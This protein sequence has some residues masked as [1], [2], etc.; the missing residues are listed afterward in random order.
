LVNVSAT[1]N[2][3]GVASVGYDS[4]SQTVSGVGM[5]N[6]IA[7][8]TV[9]GQVETVNGY[10]PFQVTFMVAVNLCGPRHEG[11]AVIPMPGQ[12]VLPDPGGG[13][14]V[15]GIGIGIGIGG[16]GGDRDRG[17]RGSRDR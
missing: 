6:G 12:A 1:S 7:Q 9:T 15:P 4:A 8:I 11:P 13:L 16:H 17:S 2:N 3:P 14:P 5:G 10:Q